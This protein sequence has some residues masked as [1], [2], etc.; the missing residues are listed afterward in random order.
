M[1][2]YNPKYCECMEIQKAYFLILFTDLYN[3]WACPQGRCPVSCMTANDVHWHPPHAANNFYLYTKS[4]FV[5]GNP[6]CQYFIQPLGLLEMLVLISS[7]YNINVL[8]INLFRQP[9]DES[10]LPWH[11]R[12]TD[13][14]P[15]SDWRSVWISRLLLRRVLLLWSVSLHRW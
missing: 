6:N 12:R 8:K 7:I 9:N 3:Y 14:G 13:K 1:F 4:C 15:V 10:Y 5:L 11:Q 2:T